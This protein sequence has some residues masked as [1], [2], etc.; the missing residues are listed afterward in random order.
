MS[1][2]GISVGSRIA[3]DM[4]VIRRRERIV[5]AVA[6]IKSLPGT[7]ANPVASPTMNRVGREKNWY[8]GIMKDD[9][10]VRSDATAKVMMTLLGLMRSGFMRI[11]F[12]RVVPM[13]SA[14]NF[15]YSLSGIG[16]VCTNEVVARFS[17]IC[18]REFLIGVKNFS[19]G[20]LGSE[21]VLVSEV[22]EVEIVVGIGVG[23]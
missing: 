8:V 4:T 21:G 17:D 22:V 18:M 5:I 6:L 14:M 10:I 1:R 19:N 13:R 3:E 16:V 7:V 23:K 2:D 20:V 12:D 11:K 9:A 15:Q